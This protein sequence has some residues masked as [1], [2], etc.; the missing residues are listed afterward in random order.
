LKGLLFLTVFAICTAI[1]KT[2]ALQFASRQK[3]SI[4]LTSQQG[5]AASI[6][7][8]DINSGIGRKTFQMMQLPRI[9]GEKTGF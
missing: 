4:S 3:N 9:A 1:A 2:N 7:N 6:D 8:H 5:Y